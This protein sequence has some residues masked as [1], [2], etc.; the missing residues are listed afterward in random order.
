MSR[1]DGTIAGLTPERSFSIRVFSV[2]ALAALAA[3]AWFLWASKPFQ[4]PHDDSYIA[5]EFAR[6]LATIGRVSYDGVH[7][8]PGATTLL[9]ILLLSVPAR[10][11]V[12][13]EW[14]NLAMGIS[15]FVLL[16]ER[17]AALAMYLAQS[18][19][20]AFY[21]ATVTAITGYLVFDALNGMETTLFMF[22]AVTSVGSIM[23]AAD[24][25]TRFIWPAVWLYF[26]ALA[27]PEGFWL[28]VSL[29]FYLAVRALS[30]R[31]TLGRSAILGAHLA[32]ALFLVMMTQWFFM[33]SITPHTALA[34]VYLFAEFRWPLRTRSIVYWN[35]MRTIWEPLL[36][37]ILPALWAKKSRRLALAILPWIVITQ[38][39][40]WLLLPTEAGAYNGR[41]LH[42]MI[43]FLFVLAGDGFSELMS[44]PGQ[45]KIPR[46]AVTIYVVLLAG[47]AYFNLVS[48][49]NSYSD[50]KAGILNNNIWA[51]RWLQKNAPS[52]IRVATHD[53][54]ALRYLGRYELVDVSG[55]VDEEAMIRNRTEHGQID[56]LISKRPDYL[57]GDKHWL[58]AFLH[59]FPTL[60]SCA[61]EVAVAHPNA[62]IGIRLRIYRFNWDQAKGPL[63][64]IASRL[65]PDTSK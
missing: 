11:G 51:V 42:P 5:M 12:P 6:N 46:W 18:E 15:F 37:F 41:Y 33:G 22:L 9:H 38:I 3:V 47:T 59:Y 21:A 52:G 43:P 19:K 63:Q 56:Y 35:Q 13:L 30:R 25:R 20:A 54:G 49:Q 45:F 53:V 36:L 27:R 17:T 4:F 65:S 16:I 26:T 58:Q 24:G 55:L 60:N 57:V 1:T 61:T 32:S 34:K 29:M 39:M 31:E 50:F 10:L 62:L 14:A 44:K 23:K 28:A 48:A 40:F 7:R 2:A 8:T 64:P